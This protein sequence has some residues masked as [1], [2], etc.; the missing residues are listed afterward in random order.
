MKN[1]SNDVSK[2]FD[3]DQ[4]R[5]LIELARTAISKKLGKPAKEVPI[6]DDPVF[7]THRGTFV[8]LKIDHQLRGCIGNLSSD[9]SVVEGVRRNALNAAFGDYRFSPLSADELEQVDIEVSILTEPQALDHSGGHDLLGK[10]RPNIDGVIIRKG[11]A[12]ATFLPQVWEQLPEPA[13]FLRHLCMKAGLPSDAWESPELEV[14]T[15]HVQYFD[16]DR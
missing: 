6:P 5:V 11:R 12:G 14:S 2:A 13:D 3:K 9:D 10:L 1:H 16:E 15:Y 7:N 8:T 4:G